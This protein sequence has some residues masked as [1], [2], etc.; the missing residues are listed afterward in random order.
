MPADEPLA[1]T[2]YQTGQLQEVLEFLK[3][4]RTELRELRK[5]HVWQDKVRIFDVNGEF[6]EIQAIGY[7]DDDIAQLLQAIGTNFKPETIN[8]PIDAPFKEFKTG[9]RHPWAED[10]IL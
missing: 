7:Q 5:V 4:T 8:K 3:R 10:R 9:R 1:S 2:I 6:F